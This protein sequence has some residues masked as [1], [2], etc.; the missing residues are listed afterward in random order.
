KRRSPDAA[1]ASSACVKSRVTDAGCASRAT[2]RPAS[3]RRS[4]ASERS[5]SSPVSMA[6]CGY[7]SSGERSSEERGRIA[8]TFRLGD[9]ELSQEGARM[10]KGARLSRISGSFDLACLA[11]ALLAGALGCSDGGG[12]VATPARL[13]VDDPDLRGAPGDGRLSLSEAIELASGTRSL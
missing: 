13:R 6:A 12:A 4:A 8:R 3:R 1:S 2:R 7:H 11:G 5:R 10:A 9:D